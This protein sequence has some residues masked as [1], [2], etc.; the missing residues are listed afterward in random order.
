MAYDYDL[1]IRIRAP[2]PLVFER[3][4]RIEHLSRWFCGWSRIEPKVGGTFR[5][6][7]ETCLFMPEGR[8]WETTIDEGETLRRFGFTWPI[9]GT[10]TRVSYELEDDGDQATLLRARHLG[11]PVQDSTCGTVEDAWRICLGNLKSIAEGRTDSVRPD[12]SPAE[13]P[14]LRFS[15]L[16]EAPPSRIFTA[17]EDPTELR[18]WIGASTTEGIDPASGRV[19]LGWDDGPDKLLAWERDRRVMMGWPRTRGDLTLTFD[20]EEKASG[21]AIYFSSAGYSADESR[22]MLRHRGRWSA[23]FVGLKNLIEGGEETGFVE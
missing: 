12:H 11:V 21:T 7:G 9:S 3:L 16:I 17:F 20:L 22:E 6:G 23:L 15:A 19:A 13:P 4:L 1:R 10:A 5:F 14:E 18:R 8:G 2:R